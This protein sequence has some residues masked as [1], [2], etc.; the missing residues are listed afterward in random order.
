M[1]IEVITIF[2]EMIE[3]YVSRSIIGKACERGDLDI[4]AHDLRQ[5][6]ED[7]HRSTDDTPYGGGPG[8]VMT[9]EPLS[10]AI[11]SVTSDGIPTR[12]IHLTPQGRPFDQAKAEEIAGLDERLLLICGRYEGID[13]RVVDKYAPEEISIGDYVLTGGEL[14]ALV[15]IDAV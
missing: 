15:I 10:K 8:M 5:F 13:E 2:P 14:P 7:R 1:R 4:R 6:T 11:E 12:I 3:A 9:V